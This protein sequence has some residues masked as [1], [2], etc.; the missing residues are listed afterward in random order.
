MSNEYATRAIDYQFGIYQNVSVADVMPIDQAADPALEDIIKVF[1][2][3]AVISTTSTYVA[4]NY[5]KD[6]FW[7]NCLCDAP[8]CQ[9]KGLW[10]LDLKSNKTICNLCRREKPSTIIPSN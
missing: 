2:D 6:W 10:M 8:D 9:G 3:N 4:K 7:L 5:E 1:E